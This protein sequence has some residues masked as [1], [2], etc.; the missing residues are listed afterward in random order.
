MTTSLQVL[1]VAPA[2]AANLCLHNLEIQRP[3]IMSSTLKEPYSLQSAGLPTSLTLWS[4]EFENLKVLFLEAPD[5]GA[6]QVQR[7]AT[8]S[9][10]TSTASRCCARLTRAGSC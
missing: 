1:A 9:T 2:K 8:S 4:G 6:A 5:S 3:A 10:S 7:R